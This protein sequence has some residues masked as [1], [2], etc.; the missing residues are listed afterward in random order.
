MLSGNVD[1]S[2]IIPT[3][4][5]FFH[6]EDGIRHYKVT[7]VQTCAL[8]IC[9]GGAIDVFF[10]GSNYAL[11]TRHFEDGEWDGEHFLEGALKD[12]AAISSDGEDIHV[13][14]RSLDGRSEERRVGKECWRRCVLNVA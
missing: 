2:D 10:R 7:G 1:V 4:A 6:T 9:A 13:L 14:V 3:S 8:P 11:W 5:F 12:Q